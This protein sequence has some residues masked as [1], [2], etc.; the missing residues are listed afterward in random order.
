MSSVPYI[1]IFPPFIYYATAP[2]LIWHGACTDYS[3]YMI[4][5]APEGV[6]YDINSCNDVCKITDNCKTF[7]F[8]TSTGEVPG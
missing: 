7:T 3:G 6:I 5:A 2:R 8:G 4:S 1:D